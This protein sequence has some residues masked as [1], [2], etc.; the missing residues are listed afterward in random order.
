MNA[1][2]LKEAEDLL[3]E[4]YGTELMVYQ[5]QIYK[6]TQGRKQTKLQRYTSSTRQR[7]A[8]WKLFCYAR[9]V[10]QVYN[11]TEI[12]QQLF[13]S[14]QGA[15]IIVEDCL[16]EGWVKEVTICGKPGFQASDVAMDE[17]RTFV[18]DHF[19]RIENNMLREA[20]ES[21]KYIRNLRQPSLHIQDANESDTSVKR[22]VNT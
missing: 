12:S 11:K 19:A 14:R 10:N 18:R 9:S 20:R 1:A 17:W 2:K 8:A 5:L 4:C 7:N 13:I 22:R 15:H 3:F 6:S 21:L 16:Q